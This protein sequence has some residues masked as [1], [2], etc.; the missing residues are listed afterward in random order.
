MRGATVRGDDRAAT[1]VL[2][3]VLTLG[4][5]ALL[6]S[7][8]LIAGGNVVDGQRERVVRTELRVVGQ[9][10][11]ADISTVDRLARST[12]QPVELTRETLSRVAGVGY[13]VEVDEVA[14][15]GATNNGYRYE[16]RLS[17]DVPDVEVLVGFSTQTRVAETAFSG[18]DVRVAYDP[19]TDD[20]EVSDG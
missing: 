5:T 4:I 2:S 20:L 1:S 6:I 18:G 10:L 12:D 15:P 9:G 8:L 3:Y 16:L 14:T 7:G 19:G 11:A 13:S 17:T